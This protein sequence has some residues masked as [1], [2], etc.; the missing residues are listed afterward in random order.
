MAA[1][2]HSM[3]SAQRSVHEGIAI[4]TVDMRFEAP[5]KMSDFTKMLKEPVGY[6]NAAK[7]SLLLMDDPN[8][9]NPK[10][11]PTAGFFFASIPPLRCDC[12]ASDQRKTPKN[13]AIFQ[14]PSSA[15]SVR[16]CRSE[17]NMTPLPPGAR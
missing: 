3:L 15:F 9:D 6:E 11:N 7:I 14:M 1:S 13:S 17:R 5:V 10:R 4:G 12:N 2:E 8:Q 16:W